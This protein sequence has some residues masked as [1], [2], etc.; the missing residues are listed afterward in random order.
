MLWCVSI[1]YSQ[2]DTTSFEVKGNCGMCEM[3]IEKAAKMNGVIQAD[4][5]METSQLLLIFDTKQIKQLEV[6]RAI[7][8]VGHSTTN[9]KADKQAYEKL[10]GCCLYSDEE[11][12]SETIHLILKGKVFEQNDKNKIPLFGANV[13][14]QES[15]EGVTTD[16]DGYFQLKRTPEDKTLIISYV[17]LNSD[18]LIV[19]NEKE[20]EVVKSANVNLRSFTVTARETPT[21]ISR[22]N[23][24]KI[25]KMTTK[26]LAKAPCCNLS[27]SFETNPS[28]DATYT[29]AVTG[30]KQIQMLGLSGP[31]IQINSG[32]LPDVRGLAAIQGLTFIPGPWV[33]SIYLN[34]GTGSVINGYESIAGQIDVELRKEDQL[35]L[36]AYTNQM[37]RVE[38]NVSSINKVNDYLTLM[39][40]AHA[41]YR[42]TRN[43]VNNDSFLDNTLNQN[44]GLHQSIS[45]EGKNGIHLSLGVDGVYQD[46]LAGQVNYFENT[47][48][49]DS[50]WGHKGAT[51]RIKGYAK[52]GK[53][54]A[55]HPDK[56]MGLQLL[57]SYYDDDNLFGSQQYYGKQTNIYAN[58]IF[59]NGIH[60]TE[61]YYKL[62][63][64]YNQ[65]QFLEKVNQSVYER[66]EIVPGVFGEFTFNSIQN[67]TAIVGL[68]GDYHSIYG[69]F[70][71]PR[72]H[73][74]VDLSETSTLRFSGGRGQ[75]TSNIFAENRSLFASSRTILV[76]GDS[77]KTEYAYG[78]RPEVAWNTGG[79]FTQTW[80]VNER[81]IQFTTDV[82]YTHFINQIVVDWE[83][84]R[85][86][87][88]YNLEG[89][90][91]ALGVQAQIDAEI[92]PLLD[93]RLAYR[94]Y[95]VKT[96]Y[97]NRGV[98]D[99]PYLAKHRAFINVGYEIK[100]KW[101]FDATVNWF[102]E[103]RLPSTSINSSENRRSTSSPSYFILSGQVTK[104]WKKLAVYAGVENALNFR[105]SNPIIESQN[106]FSNEFD[107]SMIWGP[108]FG[109]NIYVGLRYII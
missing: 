17:G 93:L 91:N 109:R 102:S 77:T 76:K 58:Y 86:V 65:D 75:R 73:V 46:R 48:A 8:K 54:F 80:S 94:F 103:Q 39:T 42:G 15:L 84:T 30:T 26:E 78:L 19:T 53:T 41:S 2:I 57:A 7:A 4:W 29:D 32:N 47:E 108:V 36:N 27:E 20:I 60:H 3:R 49:K 74:K 67:M 68:R 87:S 106:P 50:V 6:E 62:G 52:I 95:D 38:G 45:Y 10:P 21:S 105:Q 23:T 69:A 35:V 59:Q 28:V 31:N 97:K 37:G 81:S 55:E 71:T 34:K 92:L 72:L 25:E 83:N 99:K 79:S 63:V 11:E 13:Y 82:Y 1:G 16:A 104:Q 100:D 44:Y 24:L 18:T 51:R 107:A 33:K 96:T 61:N 40:H 88:F 12:S 43:D 90:S 9:V 98:L 14:W 5:D 56:S 22:F 66:T 85:E 70:L 101:M 89:K 64:S